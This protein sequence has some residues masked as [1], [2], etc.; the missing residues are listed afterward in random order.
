MR[1][2]LIGATFLGAAA[3]AGVLSLSVGAAKADIIINRNGAPGGVQAT[4]ETILN[5]GSGFP[6]TGCTT[7]V[8][9]F[10]WTS[11]AQLVADVTGTYQ[12]TFVGAGDAANNNTF[13]SAGHTFTANGP[14]GTGTG[15]TPNGTS[16]TEFLTAGTPIS[17]T[18]GSNDG[19]SL[20]SGVA[21]TIAGCNYLVA[22]ANSPTAP[23]TFDVS[24]TRGFIGFSD[25]AASTDHDF[26]D[27]VVRVDEVPEPASMALL[28]TG[29]VSLAFAYRRRTRKL[30]RSS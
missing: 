16:F 3:A 27:L 21:S 11:G 5:G 9:T 19:C 12:F 13:A 4:P 7:N 8:A 10:G 18:L 26:Q 30:D 17:F 2:Q 24:Q 20:T 1:N 25:G 15:S 28:G 23:G 22:L 6:C 29:L 14:G